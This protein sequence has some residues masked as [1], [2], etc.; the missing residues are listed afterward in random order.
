MTF[1]AFPLD[2]RIRAGVDQAGYQT[3]TPIQAK[4]LTDALAGRHILGL[5]Q[6]GT[7][8]T[9]AFA[10]PLL[11]RLIHGPRKKTRALVVAPTRE[12]AEQI[13]VEIKRLG[14]KTGL[15]SATVYGGVG[16]APQERALR[17]GAEIIVACP[18]RLLDHLSSGVGT[19]R[20]VEM[21]VLDEADH[22]F[23]MGFLPDIRRIVKQV[24]GGAQRLLFSATMPKEVRHLAEEMLDDPL[25][26]EIAHSAPAKTIEH[27][28]YP[29]HPDRKQDLLEH[30]L[31]RKDVRSALVFTRTKHRAKRLAQQLDRKG[32][33]V[34]ELQGNLTQTKRQKALDGFRSGRYDVLV[35]TDIAAR[36]ID[37]TRVSHVINFD[38]PD[39]VEA[40]THRIG[41]TGRA[42]RSGEAATLITRA[43][44]RQIRAIEQAIRA[45]IPRIV[46]EEYGGLASQDPATGRPRTP[47]APRDDRKPERTRRTSNPRT[48]DNRERRPRP[49]QGASRGGSQNT[50]RSAGQRTEQKAGHSTGPS[51]ENHAGQ[52]TRQDGGR[53]PD[54]RGPRPFKE[55]SAPVATDAAKGTDD[56]Q[57]AR[58]PRRRR[59]RRGGRPHGSQAAKPRTE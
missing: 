36:G 20:N 47:R 5:A 57:R 56:N 21:L 19:L 59:G 2:A 39:T 42:E 12:L 44:A 40:Y 22:M 16:K 51:R 18:G 37:V 52:R 25:R 53:R 49:A 26:V 1:D 30:L 13:H 58:Q 11:S 31:D 24:P 41:R 29:V 54:H 46:V 35:A 28:F 43:D 55:A 32:F 6:T 4:V 8:K 15:R 50:G 9:A 7:G 27:A 38:V 14:A 10:L 48:P 45:D 34:A 17:G 23:D 3:P 33:Q